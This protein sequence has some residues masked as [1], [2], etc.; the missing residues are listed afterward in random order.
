MTASYTPSGESQSAAIPATEFFK[1]KAS[2]ITLF[3]SPAFKSLIKV[4][5]LSTNPLTSVS[6]ALVSLIEKVAL[7]SASI[8]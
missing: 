3:M 6:Q 1:A 5:A 4:I 2:M 7:Q 8:V